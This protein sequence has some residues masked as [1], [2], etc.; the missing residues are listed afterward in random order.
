MW[1]SPYILLVE[2]SKLI[3]FFKSSIVGSREMQIY[4]YLDNK[5]NVSIRD[6]YFIYFSFTVFMYG[7]NYS[8]PHVFHTFRENVSKSVTSWN[9]EI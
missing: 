5:E 6:K 1:E 8:Q 9:F 3:F 4:L 7:Y 2:I